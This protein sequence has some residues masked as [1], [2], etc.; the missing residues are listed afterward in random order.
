MTRRS[1]LGS[2]MRTAMWRDGRRTL[3]DAVDGILVEA[4]EEIGQEAWRHAVPQN[5]IDQ[6]CIDR[7]CALRLH[8]GSTCEHSL[9]RI[10]VKMPAAVESTCETQTAEVDG[11]DAGG[12]QGTGGAPRT[13]VERRRHVQPT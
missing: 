13:A 8:A 9:Y 6:L 7:D 1:M 12:W 3:T 11:A 2:V 4:I 10:M 5:Y